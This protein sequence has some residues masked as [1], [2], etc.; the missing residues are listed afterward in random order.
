MVRVAVAPAVL[1]MFTGLVEPKLKVGRSC[2]P[3]GLDVT[4]AESVTAPVKPPDP[5]TVITSVAF[6]PGVTGTVDA[7]GATLKFGGR[8]IVKA[9]V[10]EAIR[11]P[12]VPVMVTVAEP[13]EAVPSAV[14]LTTLVPVAWLGAKAAVTPAG[15]PFAVSVTLPLKPFT[16]VMLTVSVALPPCDIDKVDAAGD[17][18]KLAG[19]ETVIPI[20]VDAVRVPEVPVMVTVAEPVAAALLAVTVRPVDPVVGFVA[21][22]AVTPL[23]KPVAARVTLPVKA[24]APVTLTVSMALPPGVREMVFA[25]GAS[26]KLGA[27]LTVSAIVVEAVMVPEVPVIVSVTAPVVAVVLAIKVR[28]LEPPVGFVANIMVT[29]LGKPVTA[30]LTL[31]VKPLTPA[32]L[33]VSMALPPTVRETAAVVGAMVKLGAAATAKL[34]CT[35]AAAE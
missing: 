15:K 16:P 7:E 31:P 35:C 8:L 28:P 10:V 18:V 13:V 1:V 23:G 5:A 22:V 34:C 20:V 30:R 32:T 26:V 25:V 4:A 19:T 24:F 2:A 6:V 29:P 11:F 3:A 27:G 17:I 33:M 14:K 21:K 12:E 9:M